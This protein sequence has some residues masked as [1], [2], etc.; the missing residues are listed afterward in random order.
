MN[1]DKNKMKILFAIIGG[2]L[3]I[4]IIAVIFLLTMGKDDKTVDINKIK[5][6]DIVPGIAFE[7]TDG[8]VGYYNANNEFIDASKYVFS[9]TDAKEDLVTFKGEKYSY[10]AYYYKVDGYKSMYWAH[11]NNVL[12]YLKMNYPADKF[13]ILEIKPSDDNLLVVD[14][15][16]LSE[17]KGEFRI[18]TALTAHTE[19]EFTIQYDA[20]KFEVNENYFEG[21]DIEKLDNKKQE[22]NESEDEEEL[23]SNDEFESNDENE[24][25]TEFNDDMESENE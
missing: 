7:T 21:Q 17:K 24:T 5:E 3:F 1:Q 25:E 8:K 10:G 6:E 9:Q 15:I 22:N 2:F 16:F 20:Y 4:A 14:V 18:E 11:Y 13:S 12:A 23:E 19:N